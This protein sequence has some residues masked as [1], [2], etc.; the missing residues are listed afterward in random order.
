[1]LAYSALD[2]GY[3]PLRARFESSL[4]FALQGEEEEAYLAQHPVLAKLGAHQKL[5]IIARQSAGRSRTYS[6]WILPMQPNDSK[7]ERKEERREGERGREEEEEEERGGTEE[8][9]GGASSSGQLPGAR[10]SERQEEAR[11]CSCSCCS[12]SCC[13]CSSQ[14]ALR[15]AILYCFTA[16]LLHCFTALL[17][18]VA[19]MLL[20]L[21]SIGLRYF[22]TLLLY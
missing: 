10:G 15:P 12:C 5:Y 20:L 3:C 9:G 19:C 1:M 21:D 6:F 13:S 16:L 7:D 4:P 2:G 17:R 14:Q 22:A 8:Q 18:L 11:S